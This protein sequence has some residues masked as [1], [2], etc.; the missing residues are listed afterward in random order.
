[1]KKDQKKK[2]AKYEATPVE[3]SKYQVRYESRSKKKRILFW[4]LFIGLVVWVWSSYGTT[5]SEL[6]CNITGQ[7]VCLGADK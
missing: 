5:I 7:A 4:I 3:K 6:L 1:M 2:F